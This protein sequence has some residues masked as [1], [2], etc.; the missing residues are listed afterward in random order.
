MNLLSPSD[1]SPMTPSLSASVRVNGKRQVSAPSQIFPP[2]N[3]PVNS[4]PLPLLPYPAYSAKILYQWVFSSIKHLMDAKQHGNIKTSSTS[5]ELVSFWNI[6]YRNLDIPETSLA[7]VLI[8][9]KMTFDL[10]DHCTL[11][12]KAVSLGL[13]IPLVS[14]LGNFLTSRSQ[15][16]GYRGA[17]SSPQHLACVVGIYYAHF[18]RHFF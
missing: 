15:V 16:E 13:L 7:V 5:H 6:L 3:P 1:P 14:R 10:V 11:S 18:S 8:Y 2:H 9:F 17:V 4:G 12:K